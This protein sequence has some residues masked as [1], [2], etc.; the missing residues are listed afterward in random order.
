[1]LYIYY[2]ILSTSYIYIHHIHSISYHVARSVLEVST[3]SVRDEG[4]TF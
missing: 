3:M 1:M 2:F 4:E